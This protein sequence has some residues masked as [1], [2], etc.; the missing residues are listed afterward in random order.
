M[1]MVTISGEGEVEKFAGPGLIVVIYL[2]P[3]FG[4]CK[5]ALI[6]FES[7]FSLQ[8]LLGLEGFSLQALLGLEVLRHYLRRRR[9]RHRQSHHHHPHGQNLLSQQCCLL[10]LSLW[11]HF[12]APISSLA[13]IDMSISWQHYLDVILSLAFSH[14]GL[15]ARNCLTT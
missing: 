7:C 5:D 13:V 6:S 14:K 11:Q 15:S 12:E 4:I 10:R 3:K 1:T 8:A 9:R 2:Q